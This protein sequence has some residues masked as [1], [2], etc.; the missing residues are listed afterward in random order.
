MDNNALWYINGT[1]VHP[2]QAT[3]SINDVAVLRGYSVFESLRTYDRRPFHLEE[4][5]TRLYRSAAYIDMDIPFSPE[6]IASVVHEAI[7]RTAYRH[8]SIRILVTG[9]ESE[10]GVLPSGKPV[11]AVLVTPLG[12]RDMQRFARGYKLMTTSLQRISQKQKPPATSLP[13]EH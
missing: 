5:L 9:G 8:A 11:L 13:C 2:R 12:E 1:W 4:H 6:Q 10:D 3:L 7:E